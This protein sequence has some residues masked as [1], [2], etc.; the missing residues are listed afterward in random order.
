L[1]ATTVAVDVSKASEAEAA[2]AAVPTPPVN[3]DA[4]LAQAQRY[5]ERAFS[6]L[7]VV[8]GGFEAQKRSFN[9]EAMQ[10]RQHFKAVAQAVCRGGDDGRQPDGQLGELSKAPLVPSAAA[11]AAKR[12]SD[13]GVRHARARPEG[14]D[15]LLGLPGREPLALQQPHKEAAAQP[16]AE[17]GLADAHGLQA[18]RKTW[19]PWSS[20]SWWKSPPRQ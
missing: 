18:E 16:E 6:V 10:L 9:E 8:V 2:A 15:D 20:Q 4:S 19:L 5:A 7:D 14:G 11:D 12:P 1:V 17:A 3:C 13:D